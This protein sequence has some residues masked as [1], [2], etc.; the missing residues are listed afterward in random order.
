MEY[1]YVFI[2][3]AVWNAGDRSFRLAEEHNL[4]TLCSQQQADHVVLAGKSGL[5]F[6]DT[7]KAF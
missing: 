3:D 4:Q 2:G 6:A 1:T 5:L 7:H